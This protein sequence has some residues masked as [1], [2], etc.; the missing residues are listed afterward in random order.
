MPVPRFEKNLPHFLIRAPRLLWLGLVWLLPVTG[1]GQEVCL[2]TPVPLAQRAQQATL[3]VEAV[4]T[5]QQAYWDAAHQNIY[6]RHTLLLYK[7]LKGAAPALLTVVT[8]GGRVGDTYHAFSGTLQ[9]TV[10]EQ[11][12]FFLERAL[13]QRQPPDRPGPVYTVYSS[14]QGFIRY[15]AATRQAVEPFKTYPTITADLYPALRAVTGAD[16]TVVRPRPAGFGPRPSAPRQSQPAAGQRTKARTAIT[17]FSPDTLAAGTGSILTIRGQHFGVTRG[18]GSVQ[19]RNADN[20]GADFIQASETDYIVWSDDEIQV[21]VPGKNSA[22]NTPGSGEIRVTTSRDTSVTSAQR[23]IIPF[24]A[25][26]V[27]YEQK[28]FMPRLVDA[29]GEGGYTFYFNQDFAQNQ[30]A[31]AAF[32]RALGTWS[33]Y[34]GVNWQTGEPLALDV[35]ADDNVNVVRFGA[36]GELPGG[37]LARC[38]SRYKGCGGATADQ[39]RVAEMD[40]VF[41]PSGRW[42]F[43]AGEP[44][45]SQFDFET[46]TLHEMGHGHQLSHVIMPGAVMHYA[47]ANGQAT[48]QLDARSDLAGGQYIMARSIASNSCGPGR[49]IPQPAQACAPL[50]ELLSFTAEPLAERAVAIAWRLADERLPASFIVE[51]SKDAARWGPFNT[52]AATG[53]LRYATTD[54]TPWAGASYYRLKILNAD[55]TFYYSALVRI[56]LAV[57]VGLAVVPNPV[58]GNRLRLQYTARAS[59]QLIIHVF[60]ALGRR[61][62]TFRRPYHVNSDIQELDVAGLSPGLYVLVYSDGTQTRR[63]KFIK[64]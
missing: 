18:T 3:I 53:A 47:I 59:G 52:L 44:T 39:W 8:E 21:R 46:V 16:F 7:T 6:T 15:D 40:L 35:T 51:R 33:C 2:L 20:G 24:A 1:W 10:G 4:V 62:Q 55:R 56:D 54:P 5:A 19:F 63:E 64:L 32:T 30:P 22:N 14:S 57:P 27:M 28:T 48:R 31:R 50:P 61:Q 23:F 41:R 43:E 36:A 37:V 9:L 26:Q 11:G 42:H 34:T 13:P 60:D 25:S 58:T 45:E 38:V 12:I 29:N 49:I 17:G